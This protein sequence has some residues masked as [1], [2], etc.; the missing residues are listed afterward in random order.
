MPHRTESE[1]LKALRKLNLLDTDDSEVFGHITRLTSRFFDVP[2]S[3]P[4]SDGQYP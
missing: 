3:G 2:V 1:R 4:Q